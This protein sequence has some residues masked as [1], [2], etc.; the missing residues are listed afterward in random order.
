MKTR[1][2]VTFA[3]LALFASSALAQETGISREDI[4]GPYSPPVGVACFKLQDPQSQCVVA[5]NPIINY[6]HPKLNVIDLN[7]GWMDQ[8]G[9]RPYIYL[10]GDSNY[11]SGYTIAV[12]LFLSNRPDGVGYIVDGSTISV[13]FPDDKDYTGK[14]EQNGRVIRWSN[15]TVW[16]KQ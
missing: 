16:T 8:G 11:S 14:I 5:G 13:Y 15:N 1:T 9:N 7:G 2:F 3:G 4:V 10:Y 6:E 12:D